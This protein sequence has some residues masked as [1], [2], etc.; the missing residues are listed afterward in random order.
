MSS[1]LMLRKADASRELQLLFRRDSIRRN[2]SIDF[3]LPVSAKLYH[4]KRPPA[5]LVIESYGVLSEGHGRGG[6]DV[7]LGDDQRPLLRRMPPYL[8]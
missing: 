6:P 8:T 3:V 5:S 2:P 7:C 4:D 1:D